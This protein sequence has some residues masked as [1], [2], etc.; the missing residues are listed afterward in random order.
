MTRSV[1][2]IPTLINAFVEDG[3]PGGKTMLCFLN[4]RIP[5][6]LRD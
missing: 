3:G 1:E 4:S 6:A 2:E 5:D